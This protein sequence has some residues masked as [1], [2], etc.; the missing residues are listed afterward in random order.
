MNASTL[1]LANEALLLPVEER[2][3]L[4][5]K[6]LN[7][8]KPALNPQQDTHDLWL[9]RQIQAGLDSANAGQL[10]ASSEVEA[11]F[12]QR[13]AATLLQLEKIA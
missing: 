4:V 7:S 12:S 6:L 1:N 11:E 8:L 9:C 13:R 10:I 5:D 2:I 3:A